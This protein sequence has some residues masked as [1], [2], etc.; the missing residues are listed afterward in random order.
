MIGRLV[1]TLVDRE[2]GVGVVDVHGV[3]YDVHAP[4][5][6]LDL[7]N[8]ATEPVTIHISTHVREDAI[9]LYGFASRLERQAFDALVSV[10]GVGPKLGLSALDSFTPDEL[11][12][13]VETDDISGLAR[14]PGVGKKTAMRLALELKGK[15]PV[16]ITLPSAPVK[17]G[18][19]DSLPLALAQLEYGKTEIDRALSVL[20]EQGIAVDAPLQQRLGAALRVLAQPASNRGGQ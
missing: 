13:A 14:I 10:S 12:R 9:T 3:G 18:P 4:S 7:W 1:G 8:L 20:L 5:R 15:L 19:V 16:D 6:C 17:R 11:Q 2:A